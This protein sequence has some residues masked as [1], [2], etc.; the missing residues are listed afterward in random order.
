MNPEDKVLP[1]KEEAPKE[2]KEPLSKDN[3]AKTEK[4][5]GGKGKSSVSQKNAR[6]R[7]KA[8]TA[9][10]RAEHNRKRLKNRLGNSHFFFWDEIND[11]DRKALFEMTASLPG[12]KNEEELALSC[13]TDLKT[14]QD[15]CLK[16]YGGDDGAV[17]LT[18]TAKKLR[19]MDKRNFLVRQQGLALSQPAMSIWLGKNYY[20]Q[21]EAD[22]KKELDL[23]DFFNV[24]I[25]PKME[26]K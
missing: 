3:E 25:K 22:E 14:L 6:A 15:W 13:G 7:E 5:K 26:A 10:E 11:H 1:L 24:I 9:I 19:A 20:G 8:M 12:F 4:A 17:T 16:V 23:S 18:N 21:K 2:G